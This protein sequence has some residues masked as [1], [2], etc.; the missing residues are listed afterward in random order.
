MRYTDFVVFDPKVEQVAQDILQ[1]EFWRPEFCR[2][3][4]ETADSIDRYES[5]PEDPVPGQELRIDSI[6]PDLY[7]SFCRH[8]KQTVQPTLEKFYGMPSSRW[9]VGWKVP[10]II[11]YTPTTQKELP[12]H[13]DDSLI[14]GTVKLN[15]DHDGGDLEFP[16]YGFSNRRCPVGS[17]LLWPS[18]IQ[19][20]HRSTPV[21]RGVKYSLV[22]W[23]KT[24]PK[25]SGI[26]YGDV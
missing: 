24:D 11:K 7:V 22:A 21:T 26:G 3:L 8:W 19:H 17:M 20:L 6:S 10:F 18:G 2:I 5:R 13:W 15:E 4:T 14:T 1:V 23:T 25:Q 9:F 16:R 12:L